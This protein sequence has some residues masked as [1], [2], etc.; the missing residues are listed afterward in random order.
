MAVFAA[1]LGGKESL[2]DVFHDFDAGDSAAE[3][4]NVHVVVLHA[5]AG[6]VGV[7]TYSGA[8][9]MDLVC[10]D[11]GPDSASA[12]DHASVGVSAC[13]VL[14]DLKGEV[15]VVVKGVVFVCAQAHDVV[16]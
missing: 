9:A 2:Q 12:N 1:K 11:T 6:A 7:G 16:T 14:G 4:E 13:D 8:H 10:G 15:W 5:L 3:G